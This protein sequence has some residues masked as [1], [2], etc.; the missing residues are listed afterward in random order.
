M[1][2]RGVIYVRGIAPGP[3]IPGRW[4]LQLLIRKYLAR[5]IFHRFRR[6]ANPAEAVGFSKA[7]LVTI[8]KGQNSLHLTPI[9]FRII[10][11]VVRPGNDL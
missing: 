11:Q 2:P 6:R 10:Q 8:A 3:G 7:I 5:R 4:L 9:S 1:T